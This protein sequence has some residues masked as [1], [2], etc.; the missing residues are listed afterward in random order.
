MFPTAAGHGLRTAAIVVLLAACVAP[1]S[2]LS[3]NLSETS[4]EREQQLV[5]AIE[6]EESLNGPYS[7]ALIGPLTA[8]SLHYEETGNHNLVDALIARVLQVIRANYGLYSLEQAPA[9]RR[10]IAREEARGNSVGAW[11]LEQ[12]LL[13]LSVRH[14]DDVRSAGIIRD[15]ADRRLNILERYEAG[16]FPPEIV[17]GCYYNDAGEHLRAQVRGSRPLTAYPGARQSDA[18]AS[19]SG[20]RAKRALAGEVMTL[21]SAAAAFY[22]GKQDFASAELGEVLTEVVRVSYRYG[23]PGLGRTA[24]NHL[25]THESESSASALRQ[26]AALVHLADWELLYSPVWGTRY[27]DSALATYE[28]AYASLIEHGVPQAEIDR[29][30][31]PDTPVVLPHFA[32]SP[33][34]ADGVHE[35]VPYVDVS[36]VVTRIGR[37]S[38]VRVLEA[39]EN[40]SRADQRTLV[41]TI[42]H[43]RFRPRMIG[44]ELADSEP[45]VARLYLTE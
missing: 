38:N 5:A 24:L 35:S 3:Q 21:Y 9:I 32:P 22:L 42:R 23:N 11:D 43:G 8:L 44:G 16:E 12:G 34:A 33:L 1:A 41:R 45:L 36:F 15:T 7:E 2:G 10:L 31:S 20:T 17:L 13:A 28:E 4:V 37:S 39:S 18:C 6:E 27:R 25:V 26:A 29:L 14:P 40:L 30:F 19:G